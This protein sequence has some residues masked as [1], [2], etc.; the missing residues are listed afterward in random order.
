MER[1]ILDL[2]LDKKKLAKG[3]LRKMER[4][5]FELV[6]T[7]RTK[8]FEENIK[9]VFQRMS[10]FLLLLF[11]QEMFPKLR[12]LLRTEIARMD[13]NKQVE[14]AFHGFYF[15]EVSR[16]ISAPIEKFFQPKPKLRP[17]TEREKLIP[18]TISRH[19]FHLV[20]ISREFTRDAQ[21]YLS[22]II[23]AQIEPLIE[24]KLMSLCEKWEFEIRRKGDQLFIDQFQKKM[25]NDVKCKLPWTKF[26]I[27]SAIS[28]M[29]EIFF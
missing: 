12:H 22:H 29:N 9:F 20:K 18:K 13:E 8:R 19:Y 16:L 3:T 23:G 10:R 26:E 4:G 27:D 28:E 24:S 7:K 21:L 15:G 25:K 1:V 6:L 2:F 5:D 14:Y 17:K 11:K